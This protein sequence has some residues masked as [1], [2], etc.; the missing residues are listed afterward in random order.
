MKY[1]FLICSTGILCQNYTF[2]AKQDQKITPYSI[3][4]NN[5]QEYSNISSNDNSLCTVKNPSGDLVCFDLY[6]DSAKLPPNESGWLGKYISISLGTEHKCGIS[7]KGGNLYCWGSNFYGQIGNGSDVYASTTVRVLPNEQFISYATG[8]RNTYA[9]T[10]KGKL[11]GWGDNSKGQLA[12]SVINPAVNRLP[13]EI[14]LNGKSFFAVTAG[15]RFFCA[16]TNEGKNSIGNFGK[17]YCS[18][19]NSSGQVGNG[20]ISTAETKLFLAGSKNYTSVS[21]GRAH[22]CAVT[23]DQ[24]VDCWGNNRIGQLSNDPRYVTLSP[25]PREIM[26]NNYPDFQNLKF[27]S[28]YLY[29]NST[30]TLTT[31]GTPYCFGD[32][33]YG[34]LGGTPS[35]GSISVKDD[36]GNSLYS[37]FEPKIP[38][39]N[40][41]YGFVSLTGNSRSTCGIT[42][43]NNLQCW[44]FI[45]K[46]TY[47]SLNVGSGNFCGISL[48]G[49]RAMCSSSSNSLSD[50]LANPWNS[51]VSTPWVSQQRFKHLAAISDKV[52]GVSMDNNLYCW[53]KVPTSSPQDVYPQLVNLSGDKVTKVAL[54]SNHVCLITDQ[55]ALKCSGE[56][57]MG[58]LGDGSYKNTNYLSEFEKITTSNLKFIDFAVTKNSTCAIADDNSVYCFGS[59]QYGELGISDGGV[60]M[61]ANPQ[62]IPNLKLDSISSGLN[63]YCGIIKDAADT[64]NKMVC[65]GDNSLGQTGSKNSTTKAP[66][67]IQNS[68]NFVSVALGQNTS[69]AVDQDNKAFCFGSNESKMINNKDTK[70]FL[71][72][73]QVQTDKRFSSLNLGIREACG[74]SSLDNTAQCWGG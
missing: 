10:A 25:V 73:V 29:N 57:T 13:K 22:V 61:N 11:Y 56:N 21:A 67:V 3:I 15:D 14:S 42:K 36:F 46:N 2:A 55:G 37:H 18:G 60:Q 69:C 39:Q 34:Q 74:V 32:N 17:V 62:V 66:F 63:H 72:P 16:I 26:S 59:N 41:S 5:N 27:S 58:Q 50:Q 9:V 43:N 24:K 45:S 12:T 48:N 20:N 38:F 8:Y 31:D 53:S 71:S 52:C 54:G 7:V 33:N 64:D 68:K 19:D 1:I 6:K 47:S 49:G 44:G 40:L 28:V 65:W 70:L 51:P 35:E 23:T 4:W 30:C